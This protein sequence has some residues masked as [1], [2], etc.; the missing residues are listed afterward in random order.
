MCG[1]GGKRTRIA[2]SQYGARH[3][4]G[5]DGEQVHLSGNFDD[6]PDVVIAGSV[7]SLARLAGP[8]G[9]DLIRAGDVEISGDAVLAQQFQKAASVR[10]P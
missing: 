3:V 2:G 4:P 5:R 1:T 7:V 8:A 10:P 9:E 6:D